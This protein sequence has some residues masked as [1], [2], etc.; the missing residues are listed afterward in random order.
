VY[1]TQPGVSTWAATL[2][3]VS[4]LTY[5][6]TLRMKTGGRSGTVTFKVQAPDANARYQRT[7]LSLPLR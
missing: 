5:R 6:V 3:K 7:S 2:T 4:G 1:V